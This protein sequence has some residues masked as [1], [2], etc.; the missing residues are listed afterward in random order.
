MAKKS[1]AKLDKKPAAP[2][3]AFVMA[4]PNDD[5]A[6]FGW[7]LGKLRYMAE[8]EVN[9]ERWPGK[10]V[11]DVPYPYAVRQTYGHIIEFVNPAFLQI[12]LDSSPE[13]R[14]AAEK[15]REARYTKEARVEFSKVITRVFKEQ[16]LP[17]IEKKFQAVA[18]MVADFYC[19]RLAHIDKFGAEE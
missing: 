4:E 12:Q 2:K 16:I 14:K 9:G 18:G 11:F 1:K 15:A 7:T 8:E 5:A 6:A 17:D 3:P 19:A 10:G 13:I